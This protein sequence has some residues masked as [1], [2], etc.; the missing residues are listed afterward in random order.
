MLRCQFFSVL[1]DAFLSHW[2]TFLKVDKNEDASRHA[3]NF[4]LL[5]TVVESKLKLLASR[6]VS[7][8]KHFQTYR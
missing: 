3:N 6:A 2:Q 8:E 7:I 5:H 4:E 1:R